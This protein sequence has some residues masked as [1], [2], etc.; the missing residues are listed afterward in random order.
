MI[1][2]KLIIKSVSTLRHEG[3]AMFLKRAYLYIFRGNRDPKKNLEAAKNCADV[4]FISG[5]ALPHPPRYRVAHQREQLAACGLV[6]LEVFY[7]NLTLDMV[8]NFRLFV[9]FRCE[10]TPL[11]EEFIKIAKAN[12]KRIIFDIDDLL[13]D[14]KYTDTI[15]YLDTMEALEREY[16]DNH[17]RNIQKLLKQCHAAITTTDRLA[18]ELKNYVPE[19]FIN[20]NVASESMAKFSQ[21]AIYDRDELPF[22]EYKKLRRAERKNYRLALKNQKERKGKLRLGYFSGSITHNEDFEMIEPDVI[23]LLD[24][25]DN[26]EL[27]VVGELDLPDS[28]KNY[29]NR[30]V[31]KKF[32]DW[33][34]LPQLLASVDINLA[35]IKQS[36]FNEAKSENKWTEAALVKVPTVAS[37]V[38]AFAFAIEHNITG[39]L[40]GSLE[41]WYTGIKSLLDDEIL[42]AK[43]AENAYA[44]AIENYL[45]INTGL[46]LLNFLKSQMTPNIAFILP[47]LQVSG[48]ALVAMKHCATL[49]MAG[50]DVTLLSDARV[51]KNATYDG[52]ELMS[53]SRVTT[54]IHQHY[55]AV[56]ATL[57]STLSFCQLYP[58]IKQRLYLVQN[59]E[60]DFYTYG[61]SRRL[62][63]N[64][65]YM[66]PIF[67]VKYITISKWCQ[68]WL[69]DKYSQD[70]DYIANGINLSRFKPVLR[71]YGQKKFRILVEGNSSDY[72]KNVDESFKI[73]NLL[74]REKYEIWYMSY[75]GEPKSWYRVDKFLHE[76]PYEKVPAVYA[77]CHIL[78]KSSI[79]ES[80]SYPP[81][82]MMATGGLVVVRPNDGNSEYLIN[83]EN[84][85]LYTD[86]QDAA[87]KIESLTQDAA[88]RERLHIGGLETAEKR[89]WLNI[90]QRILEVYERFLPK[91]LEGVSIYD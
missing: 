11:I 47:T 3:V 88:L 70:S 68:K 66:K 46:P 60:V 49:K 53:V 90:D 58:N 12:N 30:I 26:L 81:L 67:D 28:L 29:K 45:T 39:V 76:I 6:S 89:D 20:R 2:I 4:L 23:R 51:K 57:W 74:D 5:C 43:I 35:P 22:A 9:F 38:G 37:N 10:S 86:V 25:Y 75:Y 19:V 18:A 65:T 15:K 31:A 48:G 69:K 24:E 14:T 91:N 52:V 80:F 82:E 7:T 72:Y 33:Q 27:V 59:Y 36:I 13:I 77:Q 34:K 61:D 85:L 84:C 56:V 54:H 64:S 78:L 8:R 44:H 71:N 62:S 79:L 73:I 55:D 17:V 1:L 16:Y 50:Y 41:E 83:G 42:R 32:V 40:C 63:A 21:F 87:D